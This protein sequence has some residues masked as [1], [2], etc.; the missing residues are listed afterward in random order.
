M[1]WVG[2]VGW[3][4]SVVLVLASLGAAADSDV[5]KVIQF[6]YAWSYSEIIGSRVW[7]HGSTDLT[8]EVLLTEQDGSQFEEITELQV[9]ADAPGPDPIP[10]SNRTFAQ[11]IPSLSVFYETI[12]TIRDPDYC[13]PSNNSVGYV[14]DVPRSNWTHQSLRLVFLRLVEFEDADGDLAYDVGEAIASEEDLTDPSPSYAPVAVDG[15]NATSGARPL[16]VL[17]HHPNVC[18]GERWEGWIG[19]ADEEN[20]S[21]FDGLR[22]RISKIGSPSLNL[23]AYQW[24]VP[25]SFQGVNVTPFDIKLDI[26]VDGY[27]FASP[28]SR[29]ALHMNATAFSQGSATNW[30]VVPWPEG[31]GIGADSENTSAVFLWSDHATADGASAPVVGTVVPVDD[32]S[33]HVYLAYP[34]A[35]AIDHDP[36]L[37]IQD[38][39][40][41]GGVDPLPSGPLVSFALV[42]FAVTLVAA[43]AAVYLVERRKR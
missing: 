35:A 28:S 36:I 22:L 14:C 5:P 6:G 13:V 39:R 2:P 3:A 16:P 1:R 15:L 21:R 43:T 26:E 32:F 7:T 20:F 10:P 29:L 19:Q 9:A 4:A 37:G 23:T 34:Q 8:F 42:A 11:S 30:E 18:C 24:F 27:P 25:R 41:A 31:Q 38:T 33:R 17:V 40:L 12:Q